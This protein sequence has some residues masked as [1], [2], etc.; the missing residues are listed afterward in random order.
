MQGK[1]QLAGRIVGAYGAVRERRIAD[2]EIEDVRQARLG[3]I[4]V[5][6]AGVG[7]EELCDRA[8]TASIS[9]PVNASLG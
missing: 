6:D 7:V 2:R 4:L 5:P 1:A 3:E 9:T 8:V